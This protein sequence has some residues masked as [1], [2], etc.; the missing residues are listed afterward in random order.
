MKIRFIKVGQK[1]R[2]MVRTNTCE[3]LL[4]AKDFAFKRGLTKV[5]LVK[6]W[7]HVLFWWR[8]DKKKA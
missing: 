8:K 1:D 3:E 6:F 4:A 7:M 2:V 5:G